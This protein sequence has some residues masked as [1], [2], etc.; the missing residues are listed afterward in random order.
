[1]T[2]CVSKTDKEFLMQIAN[3]LDG[4]PRRP[5]DRPHGE[6]TVVLSDNF[7]KQLASCLRSIAAGI[8]S[9]K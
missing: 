7:A 8:E 2:E 3:V 9:E 4:M 1:M 5:A 6:R